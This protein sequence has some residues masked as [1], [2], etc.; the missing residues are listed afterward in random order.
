MKKKKKNEVE[1]IIWD[2]NVMHYNT[3]LMT[4]SST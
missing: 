2:V 4:P 1:S 3:H